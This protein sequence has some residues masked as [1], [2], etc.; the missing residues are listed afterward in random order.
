[1]R[2]LLAS[3][4]KA[5][6][7]EWCGELF[8]HP[9]QAVAVPHLGLHKHLPSGLASK[10]SSLCHQLIPHACHDIQCI[11]LGSLAWQPG[12]SANTPAVP[13]AGQ[14]LSVPM[15]ITASPMRIAISCAQEIGVKQ[16]WPETGLSCA[17]S[18][19]CWG[20]QASHLPLHNSMIC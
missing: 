10:L 9:R 17:I 1:M 7:Y 12:M 2:N 13:H 8:S 18:S 6:S 3:S 15:P 4:H 16:C 20:V 14:I 5:R 19:G 11:P